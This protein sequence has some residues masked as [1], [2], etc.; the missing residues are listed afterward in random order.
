MY[1]GYL[2]FY[3]YL[4]LH[5]QQLGVVHVTS[6]LYMCFYNMGQNCTM[7]TVQ[8]DPGLPL[9]LGEAILP[10]KSGWPV[11]RGDAF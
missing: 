4:Q 5:V 7:Y 8:S 1:N 9:S 3:L 11:Y 6:R 2:L 10:G